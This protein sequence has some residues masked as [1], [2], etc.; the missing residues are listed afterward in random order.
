MC[1]TMSDK[2][3]RNEKDSQSISWSDATRFVRQ[4]SHDLRNDLNAIELQSAYISELE[5]N[6]EIKKEIKRLREMISGLA[7]TLQRVSRA[8]EGVKSNPIRYRATDF[9]EDL[10]KKIERD[11]PNES[12]EI[13]WNIQLGDAT[14]NVD[15]QFFEEAF[16]ELFA[17]A[18]LHDRGRGPLLVR[19]EIDNNRFR[20]ILREPKTRF[21]LSTRAWGR[22]PLRRI[23]PRHYGLGLN[24][25][26]AIVESH[27][28]ELHAQYDPKVSALITT[29]TLPVSGKSSKEA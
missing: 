8:V 20:F 17:N 22:E 1:P 29:L 28:G 10:R 2:S 15:P 23:S 27:G 18:F 25:V 19:A 26:R 9:M 16:T 13:S 24:R 7:L 11:L 3:P 5:K 6:E 4:L 12:T 21:D 14:L